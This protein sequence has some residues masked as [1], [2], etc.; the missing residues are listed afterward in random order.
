MA[1]S[2]VDL[3]QEEGTI[4][5]VIGANG[6]GKSTILKAITGLAPLRSGY[7]RDGRQAHRRLA[8]VQRS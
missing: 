5:S 3:A 7:H 1:V 6:A 2:E 8:T 4:I